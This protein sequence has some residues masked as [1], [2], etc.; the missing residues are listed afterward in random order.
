LVPTKPPKEENAMNDNHASLTRVYTALTG[1]TVEENAPNQPDVGEPPDADFDLFIEA[2]AG[3]NIGSSSTPYT[4]TITGV[5]MT[6]QAVIPA[7]TSVT[8]QAFD[9][10]NGWTSS[11]DDFVKTQRLTFALPLPAPNAPND[12]YRF[13]VSLV[14]PNRQIASLAESNLFILL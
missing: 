1:S 4:L 12:L 6:K 9:A 13:Y 2:A 14:T 7:L 11:G 5:N 3:N 8:N 10:A